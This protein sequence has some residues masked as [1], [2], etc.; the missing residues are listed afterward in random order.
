VDCGLRIADCGMRNAECGMRIADCGLRIA[1]C[2]LRNPRMARI[3]LRG[4][5][6]MEVER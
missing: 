1:D 5:E 3:G 6:W 4:W 2:G